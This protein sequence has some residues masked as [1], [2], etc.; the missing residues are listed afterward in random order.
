MAQAVEYDLLRNLGSVGVDRKNNSY[1]QEIIATG[2][3]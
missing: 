3:K 1:W 2:R